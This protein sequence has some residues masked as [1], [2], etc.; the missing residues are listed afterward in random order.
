MFMAV[1]DGALYLIAAG[2]AS[3]AVG[4][5]VTIERLNLSNVK[6]SQTD[7]GATNVLLI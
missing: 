6:I 1:P 3:R 5:V 2:R 4:N 7:N